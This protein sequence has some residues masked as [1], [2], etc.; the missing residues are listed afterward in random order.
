MRVVFLITV[1]V[2]ISSTAMA[3]S[4]Q[5]TRHYDNRGHYQGRTECTQ[6]ECA[7]Y[8]NRG[9]LVSKSRSNQR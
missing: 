6:R 8:D 7:T 4:K 1:L 5:T 2:S 3:E 9:H